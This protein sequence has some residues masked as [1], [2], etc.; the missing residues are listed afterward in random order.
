MKRNISYKNELFSATRLLNAFSVA[1]EDN[2][3]TIVLGLS[4]SIYQYAEE[5]LITY[6]VSV[7]EPLVNLYFKVYKVEVINEAGATTVY[8]SMSGSMNNAEIEAIAGAFDST[9]T[10][11]IVEEE[12]ASGFVTHI[13]FVTTELDEYFKIRKG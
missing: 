2:E 7:L 4:D 1:T 10:E 8:V 6:I 3:I 11:P 12:S 9:V 13:E 5:E